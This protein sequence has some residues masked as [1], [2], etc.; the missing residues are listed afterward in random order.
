VEATAPASIPANASAPPASAGAGPDALNPVT[1]ASAAPF[2]SAVDLQLATL[3]DT[4]PEGD[5]WIAEVKYDGY[6]VALTLE[7]GRGRAFTRSHADWSERF[8]GLT[9]AMTEL[10]ADSAVIDGEAVVFDSDGISRFGL[11]QK[12]LGPHPE[13]VA[14]SAFDLLYLNGYDLRE[15]PLVQ[16]KE[17]LQTLLAEQ[18]ATSPIRYADHVVGGGSEFYKH[19]CL[20]DLEGVVCKRADSRHTPGRGREWV[21]I[22]CRQSQELVVGGFTEGAGSRAAL[23]SVLVG[24]YEGERLVYAGRVGSGLDEATVTSLRARLD[25]LEVHGSPFDPAPHITGHVVH[26]TRPDVVI[27]AAFREWTAE[28]VLRQ[29][30]FLGVREDKPATEV[31]RER[32]DSAAALEGLQPRDESAGDSGGAG[33]DARRGKT[34]K[35]ATPVARELVPADP[36]GVARADAIGGAILGVKITNPDKTL[37]PDSPAFTKLDF[38]SYYAAIAPLMLPEVADRPLTLLRCPTGHGRGCFYQRHPDAGLSSHIHRFKH[39]IKHDEY[40]FLYVDSAEGLVALAQMGAGEVHTWLSHTD[41]PT[42]PDRICFDLDPGPDVE[43]PQIRQAAMLVAEECEALGFSAFLKST[44]SKGLHVVLP[45]EPVWEFERVRA[46]SKAIVDRLV[47]RHPETLV[48]KMAKDARGGRIFFDYLRNAEG[49]SAVAPYSTRMKPGPSCAVP[50]AWDEL[51]DTLDIRSFT[52]AKVLER[53][54]AGID[55]WSEIADS[56]VGTKTL[57]SA[58][59]SLEG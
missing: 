16:R 20:A 25:A 30:V 47:A 19:A 9:R 5:E 40:E 52:P 24:T 33:G 39:A 22:K 35:S 51:T 4:P 15:L 3:V 36:P 26:F 23:G 55:P 37:F 2:P 14:Y 12:A 27:E 53:A 54:A 45:V 57:R 17:L 50:L 46:F 43:W 18:T 28:G 8:S 13:E 11:L 31:I 42:R 49:A 7:G 48:G 56:A 29:P 6:R 38:A 44:G 41:S 34:R 10:P 32:P 21:K 59:K 1:G 58:E